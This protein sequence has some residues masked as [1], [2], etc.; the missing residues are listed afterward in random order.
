[1]NKCG[2]SSDRLTSYKIDNG[3]R[4]HLAHH[5]DNVQVSHGLH[6]EFMYLKCTC[7]PE[8]R[9]SAQPYIPWILLRCTSGEIISG[10]CTCVAYVIHTHTHIYIY[11]KLH[12]NIIIHTC[13]YSSDI[14]YSSLFK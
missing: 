2:W 9:Q 11:K 13:I 6:P 14:T 10:G 12:M 5:I 8:T 4:L 3:Y 7:V 1:M